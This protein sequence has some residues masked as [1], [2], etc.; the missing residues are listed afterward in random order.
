MDYR[1]I[2]SAAL[3]AQYGL[4]TA[5]DAANNTDNGKAGDFDEA[6]EAHS[7]QLMY[8][9]YIML[10]IANIADTE[11]ISR[12]LYKDHPALSKKS[13]ELRKPFEFFKYIRNKYIGH[14]VP[15]LSAKTFEWLPEAYWSL[16]RKEENV[17]RLVL[18]W[19]FLET[20]INTYVDPGTG[21][22]IFETET[23]L[24]YP[25]DRRRFLN[26]LGENAEK[27]IEFSAELAQTSAS[28]IDFP[29]FEKEGLMPWVEAG[30]TD[31]EYIKKKR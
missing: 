5:H 21:H 18:S 2:C 24:N 26:Y 29:D 28:Y 17:S 16:E 12:A 15:E 9:R 25:P 22:K 6:I 19:H 4:Q 3:I 1:H 8:F 20:V 23:D 13:D 11:S 14:L 30:K 27:S 7:L 31:F 10:E